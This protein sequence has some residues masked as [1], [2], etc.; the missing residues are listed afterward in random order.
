L[1][2]A[3]LNPQEQSMSSTYF[4]AGSDAEAIER[5]HDVRA[6]SETELVNAHQLITVPHVSGL[7]DIAE[8]RAVEIDLSVATQV[9]PQMPEDPA[10]DLSWMGEPIVERIADDLRDRLA[11]IDLVGLPEW[12]AAWGD[13]V[14]GSVEPGAFEQLAREL[15]Q[16]AR[17]ASQGQQGLYNCYEL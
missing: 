11:A 2:T 9:W 7:A 17:R 13:E 3:N 4:T 8:G 1:G 10:T 15:V 16:L 14:S 6:G 5:A 12:I